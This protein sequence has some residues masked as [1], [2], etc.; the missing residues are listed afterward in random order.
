M[1]YFSIEGNIGAGK[2]AVLDFIKKH[3][4][5]KII[6]KP[7]DLLC[8]YNGYNALKLLF[9]EPEKNSVPALLH[10]IDSIDIEYKRIIG[11][12]LG[13]LF[14]HPTFLTEGCILSFLPYINALYEI[15]ILSEFGKNYLDTHLNKILETYPRHMLPER[16]I[17]IDVDPKSCLKRI[18]KKNIKEKLISLEFLTQL[19]KS[20]VDYLSN[21]NL[22][23]TF[24]KVDEFQTVSEVADMILKI[25]CNH[26]SSLK[27]IFGK[28][29]N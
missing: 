14:N 23:V 24:L 28:E 20:S 4:N 13:D 8:D 19:N 26:D 16:L 6:Q 10:Y 17:Y 11:S 22:P 21:Q 15:N 25:I 18:E 7:L 12:Y 2:T 29:K 5:C 27:D 3:Y 1:S 9:Q